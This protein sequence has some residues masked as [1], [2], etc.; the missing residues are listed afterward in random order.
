[1]NPPLDP[2]PR[3]RRYSPRRQ[4]RLDAETLAKLE[5]LVSALRRKRAAILRYVIQWGLVHAHGWMV[6]PSIPDRSHLVHMLVEPELLQEVQDAADSHGVSMAAWLRHA[7]HQVTR[8]DFPPSWHAGE[9]AVRSHD[10]RNYRT[11]F[12]L[13]LDDETSRKLNTL[14]QTFHRSAAEVIRQLI[15][16]ANP[17]D[18]PTSWPLAVEER[19]RQ[20]ARRDA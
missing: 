20:E 9:A 11:R 3:Q 12:M 2:R 10:S 17:E 13:R 15:A 5:E 18:F 14:T 8:D 1:V 16:Q 19:R 6:D 7:M 4:A